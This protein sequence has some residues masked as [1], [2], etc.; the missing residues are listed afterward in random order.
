MAAAP[1]FKPESLD[2]VYI[3]GDHKFKYVAEDISEWFWK[4]GGMI[5]GHDYFCTHPGQKNLPA[6]LNLL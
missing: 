4:K 3:D 1:D 6:M 2:F 5:A